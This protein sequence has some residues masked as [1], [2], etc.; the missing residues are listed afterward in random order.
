METLKKKIYL[1]YFMYMG[2][3]SMCTYMHYVCP[4]PYQDQKKAL[5]PWELE[6]QTIVELELTDHMGHYVGAGN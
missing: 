5:D 1:F 6:L 3:L 2:V 4:A